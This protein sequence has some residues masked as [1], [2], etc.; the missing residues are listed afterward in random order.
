MKAGRIIIGAVTTIAILAIFTADHYW[1][2]GFLSAALLSVVAFTATLE[3][4]GVLEKAGVP[5]F[6]NLASFASL[7]VAILPAC[8]IRWRPGMSPFAPQATVVFGFMVI[9][10]ALAM[11]REDLAAGAKAVVGGTFT[12][13]YVGLALSFLVRL[14][15]FPPS[16]VGEGL[17]LFSIGCAKVGDMGAYFVGKAFGRH[18]LSPR[19]SPKKTLEGAMGAALG[20]IAAALIIWGLFGSEIQK[21]AGREG[22]LWVLLLWS[23]ILSIAAQFGDLA[24]SLLKRAGGVKDSGGVFGSMGG[25]LDLV[26]SL[27]IAAPVAYLLAL[28]EGFGAVQG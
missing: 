4:C 18:Q 8:V 5:T 12:V 17:L 11:K 3:L 13:I 6:P 23:V 22:F 9:T 1:T 19:L 25:V 16:D 2:K 20:S 15:D 28:A 24:E 26:D 7:L 27:L 21:V 14:R 10:F